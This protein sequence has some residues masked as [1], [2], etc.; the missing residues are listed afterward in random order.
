MHSSM[1]CRAWYMALLR[2]MEE[3]Q[4]TLMSTTL[5]N[6]RRQTHAPTATQTASHA[7]C[8]LP[9]LSLLQAC[10]DTAA[11]PYIVTTLAW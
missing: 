3:R 7:P 11:I 4:V 2:S 8:R 10:A 6:T 5:C 9:M 1:M